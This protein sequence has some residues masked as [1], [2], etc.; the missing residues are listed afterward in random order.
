MALAVLVDDKFRV[1]VFGRRGPRRSSGSA[2]T[3]RTATARS[4]RLLPHPGCLSAA[5]NTT[6]MLFSAVT[7]IKSTL[8]TG[9]MWNCRALMSGMSE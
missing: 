8:M 6:C 1:E 7:L 5:A 2:W 4:R 9:N 3:A